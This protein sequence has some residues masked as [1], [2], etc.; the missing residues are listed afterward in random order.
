MGLLVLA[1]GSLIYGQF[2]KDKISGMAIAEDKTSIKIGFIKN[3]NF[4][5]DVFHF[6]KEMNVWKI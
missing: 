3:N 6:N 2:E 1:N 5:G 4:E